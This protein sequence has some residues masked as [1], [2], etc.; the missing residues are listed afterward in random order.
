SRCDTDMAGGR[1][2]RQRVALVVGAGVRPVYR[3]L[4]APVVQHVEPSCLR[5]AHGLPGAAR[6]ESLGGCPA[7][8]L[9]HAVQGVIVGGKQDAALGWNGAH[10]VME[11]G[12]YGGEVGKDVG[13]VEFQVVQDGRARAVV[14]ELR[15]LVEE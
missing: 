14:D 9:Q 1:D 4:A 7:S 10:E 8:P 3:S 2:R 15:S 5:F 6:T 13:V 11:L 12:F